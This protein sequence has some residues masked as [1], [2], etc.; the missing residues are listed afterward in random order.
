MDRG[1]AVTQGQQGYPVALSQDVGGTIHLAQLPPFKPHSV[2]TSIPREVDGL[3]S[4]TE[5]ESM[6]L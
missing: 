3:A 1:S 5:V 4:D 6:L 2:A